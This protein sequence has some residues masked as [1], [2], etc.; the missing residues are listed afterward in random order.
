MP[1]LRHFLPL[2]RQFCLA[3]VLTLTG[4]ALVLAQSQPQLQAPSADPALQSLPSLVNSLWV[5]LAFWLVLVMYG[6][7]AAWTAGWCRAKN[8]VNNFT[9]H[10]F[11]FILTLFSFWGWGFALMFGRGNGWLG[12][13]P[14]FLRGENPLNY[15][16]TSDLNLVLLFLFQAA[17]AGLTGTI[18]ARAMAERVKFGDLMI[19]TLA[20]VSII[21][22][23]VGHWVWGG[24]WLAKLGFQDFAGATVIHS[25][26]GWAAF[27]GLAIL[28]PRMGKYEPR[29]INTLPGHNLGLAFGG[30]FLISLGWFGLIGG[31]GFALSP[32]MPTLFLNLLLAAGAAGLMAYA[33]AQVMGKQAQPFLML[34]GMLAGFVAVAGGINHFGW[35][36]ATVVGAIAGFL[37]VLF[38]RWFDQAHLDDPV[39]ALSVHLVGGIWGTLAVGL[40]DTKAGLIRGQTLLL[41]NQL[42]GVAAIGIFVI[43]TSGVFWLLL[44]ATTGLR[45]NIESEIN[46]LDMSQHNASLY[47]NGL[48]EA[49]GATN[50]FYI[51]PVPEE[52][53]TEN[54]ETEEETNSSE[55]SNS[56]DIETMEATLENNENSPSP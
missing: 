41:F 4:Q 43:V 11:I 54:P 7:F 1:N 39:G 15:T 20:L 45:V 19:F 31:Q 27:S 18:V 49:G 50:P 10:L 56:R 17:I 36:V 2:G 21:Y 47:H 29:R 51:P 12:M 37:C 6:G 9:V 26:G 16:L 30:F 55:E 44:R 32:R 53:A 28:G 24:G 25:V 13:A 3:L 48:S 42:I 23:V 52:T 40:F 46:G 14:W 22:P 34:N 8:G 33:L 5:I 35:V 38:I